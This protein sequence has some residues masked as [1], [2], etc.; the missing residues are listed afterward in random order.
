MVADIRGVVQFRVELFNAFNTPQFAM[1]DQFL[2]D[3]SFGQITSTNFA[4]SR[5]AV[6]L[7]VYL[8]KRRGLGALASNW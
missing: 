2:G 4:Q 1:P 8:L 3:G 6:R 5:G 7:A